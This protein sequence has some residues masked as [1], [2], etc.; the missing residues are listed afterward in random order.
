MRQGMPVLHGVPS[1]HFGES[2]L[3]TW[4]SHH[5]RDENTQLKARIAER[6]SLGVT[7]GRLP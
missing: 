5:D 7:A 2:P 4:L 3:R 1:R 6:R